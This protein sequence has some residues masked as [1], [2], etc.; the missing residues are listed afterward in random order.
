MQDSV[1]DFSLIGSKTTS[2]RG[3]S[4][5]PARIRQIEVNRRCLEELNIVITSLSLL[6][7]KQTNPGGT[8]PSLCVFEVLTDFWVPCQVWKT[9]SGE[10]WMEAMYRHEW[11][12]V[13][14][15]PHAT[16]WA[17]P[18]MVLSNQLAFLM[19]WLYFLWRSFESTAEIISDPADLKK[20]WRM[21]F[22]TSSYR[23][24]IDPLTLRTTS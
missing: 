23:L 2:L 1:E 10:S 8:L 13:Y 3:E 16:G 18:S 4:G 22:A 14:F 19:Y 9:S 12:L 21:L 20:V 7:L 11:D 24:P 6:W 15:F 5:Y 17:N